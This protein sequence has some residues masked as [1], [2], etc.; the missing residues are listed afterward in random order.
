MH[1]TAPRHNSSSRAEFVSRPWTLLLLR[2]S[3]CWNSRTTRVLG[4]ASTVKSNPLHDAV[5]MTCKIERQC[6]TSLSSSGLN[7]QKCWIRPITI[8]ERCMR[9]TFSPFCI[10]CRIAVLCSRRPASGPG[11]ES[12]GGKRSS[13]DGY[14]TN[15][16]VSATS[17]G[18]ESAPPG[19]ENGCKAGSLPGP[20][21]AALTDSCG[22]RWADAEYSRG[23]DVSPEG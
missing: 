20:A 12:A 4:A 13:S 19:K 10:D 23:H 16:A 14:L 15:S 8:Q 11:S 9:F 7:L 18:S 22:S 2:P 1:K 5:R 21:V 6:A 3:C 17:K